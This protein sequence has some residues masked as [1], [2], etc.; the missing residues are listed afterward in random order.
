MDH[1][2]Q[3]FFDWF[4]MPSVGLPAVFVSALI[5]ATMVPIG[6]EPILFGFGAHAYC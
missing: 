6:S 3:H 1:F 2:F 5:S 4:G